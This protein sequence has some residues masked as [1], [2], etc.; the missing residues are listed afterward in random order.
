[1]EKHPF[2]MTKVPEN[3]DDLPPAVEGNLNF[4]YYCLIIDSI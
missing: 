1:M 4:Y 2:F 3:S